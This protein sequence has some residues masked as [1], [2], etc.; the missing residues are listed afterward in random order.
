MRSDNIY[1]R[2]LEPDDVDFLYDLEN[3]TSNWLVSQT[4]VPFSKNILNQYIQS[5]QDIYTTNQIRFVICLNDD[6]TPI[7]SIDLFEFD[8]I[9]ERVGVGLVI[10]K[11][12]RQKGFA[13]EALKHVLNYCF[14]TLLVH[15]VFCNILSTNKP[16]ISLFENNGF[17]LI[18]KKNSWYKTT[19]G[20]EDELMFQ[21]NKSNY[22]DL[23]D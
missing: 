21:I 20:W 17:Y 19:N 11:E 15:N 16:S 1:L 4:R 6:N 23:T 13:N 14:T 2:T 18:G 12:Y 8:P 10:L 5:A 9:N 7:G 22:I 3:D